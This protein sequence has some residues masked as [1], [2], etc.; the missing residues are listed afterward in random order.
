MQEEEV[1][2]DLAITQMLR[3]HQLTGGFLTTDEGNLAFLGSAKYDALFEALEDWRGRREPDDKAVI[4]CKFTAEVR[5]ICKMLSNMSERFDY[6]D[7]SH[8]DPRIW[9]DFQDRPD[10]RVLVVQIE[11][12]GVGIDLF[13]A[14]LGIFFSVG[15]NY[16]DYDQA[17]AR[18]LRI[19]QEKTVLYLHIMMEDTID[20]KIRDALQSKG[21]LAKE[22]LDTYRKTGEVNMAKTSAAKTKK[23]KVSKEEVAETD[24]KTPA[25][26]TAKGEGGYN[27]DAMAAELG[28][29]AFTVRMKLRAAGIEKS[30]RTYSWSSK[31]EFQAALAKVRGTKLKNEKSSSDDE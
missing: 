15:L 24:A 7:G 20:M 4:F 28:L 9:Q 11:T 30:G 5:S 1:S 23:A 6:F 26:S 10:T 3:L 21:N 25:A 27:V 31:K 29:T 2:V 8:N 17:R 16:V 13:R 18:L 19:G 22:V 12:G 14:N